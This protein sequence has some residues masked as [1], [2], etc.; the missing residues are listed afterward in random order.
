MLYDGNGGGVYDS[1][2]LSGTIPATCDDRG[3]V[4]VPFATI[5]NGSPDGLALVHG[6]EV[7][8]FLSYEGAISATDGPATGQISQPFPWR[9]E[10][11]L[12]QVQSLQQNGKDRKVESRA[13]SFGRCNVDGP[14]DF[15]M[16]FTGR[17]PISD[18]AL[19]VGFEDQLFATMSDTSGTT[20]A[21]H[22]HLGHGYS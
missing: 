6:S 19:P 14:P 20:I 2:A 12:P 21:D 16:T 8:E 15:D 3:V 4:V 11:V 17:Q 10:P 22:L 9:K 18:P 5:Q 7:V 13:P 1:K